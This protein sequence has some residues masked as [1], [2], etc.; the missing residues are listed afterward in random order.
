MSSGSDVF[1]ASDGN[2]MLHLQNL[3]NKLPGYGKAL[4][5][6]APTIKASQERCDRVIAALHAT[7]QKRADYQAQVEA[8]KA[9][10]QVDLKALRGDIRL[11]K[12]SSGYTEAMGRDLGVAA[13]AAP[14]GVASFFKASAKAELR[15]S[16]VRIR[17]TKG[18]LDGVN[19][20]LRRAGDSDWRLLGRD[21][22]S[23]YDDST[24]L[25]KPG[26]P[27]GREYRV[28]GVVKDLEVGTP[29][30]IIS[31]LVSG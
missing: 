18:R 24:P 15:G 8:T 19:V 17:W 16:T 11:L 7:E 3:R 10:K 14:Q 26:V 5:W 31:V 9:V 30:D 23:P 2:L 25:L 21:T 1:P 12:A 29:S 20:Y 13:L 28:I 4:A 27:E 6:S 22:H